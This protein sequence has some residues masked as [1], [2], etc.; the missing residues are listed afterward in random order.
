M[1]LLIIPPIN[2]TTSQIGRSFPNYDDDS[3]HYNSGDGDDND[4]D[5]VNDND[6]VDNDDVDDDD[7][8]ITNI[9]TW[10]WVIKSISILIRTSQN[11]ISTK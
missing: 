2:D 9:T 11:G 10:Q 7:V 3:D 8:F 6:D 4:D 5:D 1:F